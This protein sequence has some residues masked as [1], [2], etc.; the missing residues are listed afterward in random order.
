MDYAFE[1]ASLLAAFAEVIMLLAI[2]ISV[3]GLCGCIGY[4]YFQ[5]GQYER[6]GNIVY[7]HFKRREMLAIE[8]DARTKRWLRK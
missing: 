5:K 4:F 3:L 8:M 7:K 2:A 1:I 6:G